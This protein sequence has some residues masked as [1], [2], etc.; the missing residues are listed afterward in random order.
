GPSTRRIVVPSP[1]MPCIIRG[2]G[3]EREAL[4]SRPS[5][6]SLQVLAR[7]LILLTAALA[8]LVL[9]TMLAGFWIHSLI[10]KWVYWEAGLI[11]LIALEVAYGLTVAGT[12]LG[13]LVLGILLIRTKGSRTR[14]PYAARGLLLCL[15]IAMALAGAEVASAVWWTRSRRG[16]AVPAG[17]RPV[18]R[19]REDPRSMPGP[20][21]DID[22]PTEFPDPRD[23][24]AIDIVVMGESSAEGV[25][26]NEWVSIGQM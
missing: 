5:P 6:M 18:E 11:F 10:P 25:P 26:Y 1:P 8:P 2:H 21:T 24:R 4:M 17:R 22:A 3:N 9:L 12:L 14:R 19:S 15:S 23:D 7:R 16:S 13:T 20:W